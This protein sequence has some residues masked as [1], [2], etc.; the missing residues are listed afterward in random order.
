MSKKLQGGNGN[1]PPPKAPIKKAA[2]K[3]AKKS[4]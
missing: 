1:E 4:K 3:P 2:K